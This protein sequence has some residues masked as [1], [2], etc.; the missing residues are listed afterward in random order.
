MSTFAKK[1]IESLKSEEEHEVKITFSSLFCKNIRKCLAY[2]W[3]RRPEGKMFSGIEPR[4]VAEFA[5]PA[6]H[7]YQSKKA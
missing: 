7:K 1:I 6:N 4:T 3:L 2:K 5:L